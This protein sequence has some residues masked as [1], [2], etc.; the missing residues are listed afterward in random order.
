MVVIQESP[1]DKSALGWE[2]RR[3]EAIRNNSSGKGSGAKVLLTSYLLW[4]LNQP[5]EIGAV[6]STRQMRKLSIEAEGLG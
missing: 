2:D 4:S 3:S 5:G 6:R 1:P